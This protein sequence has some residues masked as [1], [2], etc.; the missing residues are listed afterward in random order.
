MYETKLIRTY[1]LL[2][3]MKILVVGDSY[4]ANIRAFLSNGV[5]KYEENKNKTNLRN[6][7]QDSDDWIAVLEAKCHAV[8]NDL[9]RLPTLGTFGTCVTCISSS[10]SLSG[11]SGGGSAAARR[12]V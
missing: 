5:N 1:N 6:V 12:P 11:L 10:G 3:I 8:F 4:D 2:N 9:E 7:V